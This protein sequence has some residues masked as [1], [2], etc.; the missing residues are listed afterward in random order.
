MPA[1]AEHATLE[2]LEDEIRWYDE[3]SARSQRLFKWLKFT[4]IVAAAAIPLL[5]VFDAPTAAAAVLGGVILV[6]EGLQHVNQYQSNWTTYRTTCEAL[7]HEKFLYLARAGP[8]DGENPHPL[9][10]ERIEGL[11]S[12][13]NAMWVS[14]RQEPRQ[15][16]EK[17]A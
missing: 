9:L 13:E 16:A 6:L 8:Y 12:Q 15:P 7:K 1:T 17:P 2:R 5:A 4:E 3:K 10:A 11:I 14:A